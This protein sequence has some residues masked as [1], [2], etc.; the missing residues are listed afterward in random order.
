MS[1]EPENQEISAEEAED[2]LLNLNR[3]A[4]Y[5]RLRETFKSKSLFEIAS[6]QRDEGTHSNY[7][8]WLL[9]DSDVPCDWRDSTIAHLLDIILFRAR[10]QGLD[11]DSKIKNTILSRSGKITLL[12]VEREKTTSGVNVNGKTGRID[13]LI[14]CNVDCPNEDKKENK[15]IPIEIC[16]ENKVDSDEHDDQTWKY[17]LYLK[18]EKGLDECKKSV[19]KVV[20]SKDEYDRQHSNPKVEQL[21]VFL[22]PWSNL[23]LQDKLGNDDKKKKLCSCPHYIIINYQDIMDFILEPILKM[24]NLPEKTKFYIEE[25]INT[26]CIPYREDDNKNNNFPIMAIDNYTRTLLS[27]FWQENQR[28]LLAAVNAFANDDKQDSIEREKASRVADLMTGKVSFKIIWEDGTQDLDLDMTAV[29]QK[30]IKYLVEKKKKS[31]EYFRKKIIPNDV[32]DSC[33]DKTRWRGP[34]EIN[35][36]NYYVTNQWRYYGSNS[37]FTNFLKREIGDKIKIELQK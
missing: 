16:I 27:K 18:G 34:I 22:T 21:F 26:L 23:K 15:Y 31:I 4:N 19:E 33:R 14:T 24:P 25:Y 8:Q 32:Y 11:I 5:Q 3:S 7:I 13:L 1:S 9:R 35:N 28:L 17:W 29:V 37:N 30:I 12:S 6:K 10:E 2:L 36:E 20:F